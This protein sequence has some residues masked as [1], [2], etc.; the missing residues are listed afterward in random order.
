MH[1]HERLGRIRPFSARA[2][3]LALL[4]LAFGCGWLYADLRAPRQPEMPEWMTAAPGRS[5]PG[6]YAGRNETAASGVPQNNAALWAAADNAGETPEAS[7]SRPA[8]RL[9]ARVHS[10]QGRAE[11][12]LRLILEDLRPAE[13]APAD[14]FAGRAIFTWREPPTPEGG[15]PSKAEKAVARAGFRLPR[16]PVAGDTLEMDLRLREIHGL[17]NPG[18]WNVE[19]YWAGRGVWLR[20][21]A[22]GDAPRAELK[23][24][25]G[26]GGPSLWRERLRLKTLAA[27]PLDEQGALRPGA[28]LIP[29]LLFGDQYLVRHSDLELVSRSTLAH[30]LALSGLHLGYA[31]AL[32][33][34]AVRLLYRLRPRLAER[35]PR[36]KAAVLAGMV[37]ALFYLWLGASAYS[38]L[39]SFLML[40]FIGFLFFRNRRP[41]LMDALCAVL[42]VITLAGPEALFELSLQLSA[43]CIAVISLALPLNRALLARLGA[44]FRKR[45]PAEGYA[46]FYP[47]P[48]GRGQ[49]LFYTAARGLGML[50]LTSLSIQLALAPLLIKSFGFFGL[51]L[52]LNLIWLPVLG[53]LALPLCFAGLAAAALQ[54]EGLAQALFYLASLP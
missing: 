16:R 13:G 28:E 12:N 34:L 27:L 37:P 54:L 33:Y 25:E 20:A 31:A 52:P 45:R 17:S 36:T 3:F 47:P 50:L 19:D 9:R 11:G 21:W 40:A 23:A 49:K 7:A 10:V 32:G 24:T 5:Q 38:L 48:P 44:M 42:G 53:F 6:A 15:R 14:A 46:E 41:Q 22:E 4:L 51:A 30:S 8:V 18:L 29:A 35:L 43:A 39:R 2:A 26:F 1:Q